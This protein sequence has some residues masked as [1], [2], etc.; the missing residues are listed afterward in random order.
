MF[1]ADGW[2]SSGRGELKH[3]PFSG[4]QVPQLSSSVAS[5]NRWSAGGLLLLHGSGVVCGAGTMLVIALYEDRIQMVVVG[6]S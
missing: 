3:G 6:D 5:S 1:H 4:F 2:M